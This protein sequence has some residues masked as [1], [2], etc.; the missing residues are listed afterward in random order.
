MKKLAIFILALVGGLALVAAAVCLFCGIIYTDTI[1]SW[2]LLLEPAA[3]AC[4]V[5]CV[6]LLKAADKLGGY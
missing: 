3:V 6:L 1:S 4:A 2:Y 5:I